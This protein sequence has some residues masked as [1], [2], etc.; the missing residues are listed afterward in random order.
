MKRLPV[1]VATLPTSSVDELVR[2]DAAEGPLPSRRGP[3]DKRPPLPTTDPLGGGLSSTLTTP[4]P[5]AAL[6]EGIV[7]AYRGDSQTVLLKRGA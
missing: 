5:L 2:S 1:D 3:L 6:G 7:D 4:A